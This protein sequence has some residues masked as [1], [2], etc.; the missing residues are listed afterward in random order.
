MLNKVDNLCRNVNALLALIRVKERKDDMTGCQ[1]RANNDVVC[2]QVSAGEGS[3][4]V[5]LRAGGPS[6]LSCR[7]QRGSGRPVRP[8]PLR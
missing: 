4:P 6:L 8:A 1:G 5:G 3:L 2:Q 7:G